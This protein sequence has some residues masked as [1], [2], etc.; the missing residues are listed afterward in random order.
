MRLRNKPWAEPFLEENEDLVLKFDEDLK[1]NFENIFG[2]SNSL[3]LE[4]G[5]GKGD[6]IKE[7]A[8]LNPNKNYVGMEKYSTVLAIAAKKIKNA[9]D[10]NNVRLMCYDAG[11]VELVFNYE[12][13]DCIYLNFSDPWPKARHAKRRLPSR[14]FLARFDQILKEGGVIE[15]K[16][17]NKDLFAFAEE[18]VEP[19]GW[20]ILEITYDLHND[21]KM[22]EGNIMTEYE[23]KFSSM[24][25]PIYK[26]IITR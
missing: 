14:Q 23:E 4:I 16:T 20:K 17:D 18:E 2:N 13:L 24:G 19:A 22:V 7:L 11:E 15:F 8:R 3:N 5:T 25:N 6:F 9:E 1:N 21:E 10:I 12:S 26:Y